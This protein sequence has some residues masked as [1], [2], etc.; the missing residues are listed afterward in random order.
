MH[1]I[2]PILAIGVE[3]IIQV[4][5]FL[6]PVIWLVFKLQGQGEEKQPP[7]EPHQGEVPN[8]GAAHA[9]AARPQANPGDRSL[10]EEIEVFLKRV[11]DQRGP[12]RPA[13]AEVLRPAQKNPVVAAQRDTPVR[14]E[15]VQDTLR[16]I[17]PLAGGSVS[18]HVEQHIDTGR[19]QAH[20]SH[21]GEEVGYADDKLE[22]RLHERF[23]H[24]V[25][26]LGSSATDSLGLQE[27]EESPYDAVALLV[28]QSVPDAAKITLLLRSHVGVRQA[29][30]LSEILR[31]PDERW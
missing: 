20:A 21:L 2:V 18:T 22:S 5:I 13:E 14:A 31:R 12:Q 4:L 29:I 23:D 9:E 28:D 25:G 7:P 27:S 30:I 11:A 19:L 8:P 26:R 16:D 6:A 3:D 10:R 15:V 24:S 17:G 1:S